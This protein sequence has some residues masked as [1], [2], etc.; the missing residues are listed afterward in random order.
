MLKYLDMQVD[1]ILNSLSV[2]ICDHIQVG[3]ANM[4]V[5]R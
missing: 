3:K 4:T 1:D 5:L 2:F